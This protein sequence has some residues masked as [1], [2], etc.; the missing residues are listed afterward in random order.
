MST[1]Q[2]SSLSSDLGIVAV[3]QGHDEIV[4]VCLFTSSDDL[5]LGDLFGRDVSSERDVEPNGSGV[6]S[7]LL[8]D[9]GDR[10]AVGLDV[11][12]RDVLSIDD[13]SS[14]ERVAAQGD[15]IGEHDCIREDDA[16]TSILESLDELNRCRFS[17]SRRSDDRSELTWLH[18]DV[19]TTEN[20]DVRAS[21][22]AEVDVL[23][24]DVTSGSSEIE[25]FAGRVLGV[26][27]GTTVDESD[28]SRGGSS[29]F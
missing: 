25:R 16:R 15:G 29:S 8:R 13:N 26:D 27:L 17:R 3:R 10:A 5:F 19:E 2:L 28:E 20:A 23:E 22:V 9:E 14:A 11:E 1:R 12:V 24:S 18:F 7:R 21:R 6:E 4:N